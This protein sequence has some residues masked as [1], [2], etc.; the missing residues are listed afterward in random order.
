MKVPLTKGAFAEVSDEDYGRVMQHKWHI[1]SNGYAATN[2]PRRKRIYLHR[3]ILNTPRRKLTDHIDGN[4][5]N[6]TRCNLRTA[7][8]SQNSMNRL[9]NGTKR[10][11]QF[12]GVFFRSSRAR[13][14]AGSNVWESKIKCGGQ[15][16]HLGHFVTEFDAA[17]AYNIAAEKL[18]GKFA[19]LNVLPLDYA[20]KEP[21]RFERPRRSLYHHVSFSKVMKRWF[22]YFKLD[23]V[24][25][26]VGYYATE[27]EAALAYN[28]AA[29]ATF[30][31]K[32]RLNVVP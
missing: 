13:L 12:K 4:K 8:P 18:H 31:E 28:D 15:S 27:R 11:S 3:F 25:T 2:G 17:R 6:C 29:L 22:A 5:L 32:A 23:G 9:A 24:R 19:S 1:T 7:T 26:T 30:G 16:T 21:K 10:K 20:S 14:S